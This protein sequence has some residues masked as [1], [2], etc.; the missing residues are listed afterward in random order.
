MRLPADIEG[1]MKVE[2][3]PATELFLLLKQMESRP[4]QVSMHLDRLRDAYERAAHRLAEVRDSG[5]QED[6][7][8]RLN[9]LVAR[10]ARI[11][12]TGPPTSARALAQWL[13]RDAGQ[14][15]RASRVFLIIAGMIML[16]GFFAGWAAL[17]VESRI[18]HLVI[19]AEGFRPLDA[20][21]RHNQ[22]TNMPELFS[23]TLFL[24]HGPAALL[25][26]ASGLIIGIGPTLILFWSGLTMGAVSTIY[27]QA[28]AIASLSTWLLAIGI[29]GLVIIWL[30][31]SA[32]LRL[33]WAIVD[34][35]LFS[36]RIALAQAGRFASVVAVISAKILAIEVVLAMVML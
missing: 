30:S 10:A 13:R 19:P 22:S 8:D 3:N 32:G 11:L 2:K 7:A 20:K 24:H 29:P 23:E 16:A 27:I 12:Y 21:L 34:P 25:A 4:D 35:G 26:I 9:D 31:G 28:G 5:S 1:S 33:G 6:E 18:I 36:R 15:L 14:Q 17:R